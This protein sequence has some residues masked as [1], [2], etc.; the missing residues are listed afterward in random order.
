MLSDIKR[1]QLMRLVI[2]LLMVHMTYFYWSGILPHQLAFSPIF[3]ISI[4]NTFWLFHLSGL[5]S[6]LI[7]KPFFLII[8][9]LLLVAIAIALI[10]KDSQPL[11]LLLLVVYILI[12]LLQQSYSSTLTKINVIF[13]IVWLPFCFTKGMFS[14]TWKLPRYYLAYLMVS[15]GLFKIINGGLFNTDQLVNILSNQ[16]IDLQYY[17]SLNLSNTLGKF[18][19]NNSW[20]AKIGYLFMTLLELSFI[21]ILFTKRYDRIMAVVLLFFCFSIFLVMRIYILDLT[22]LVLV[23]LPLSNEID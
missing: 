4:D 2:M 6:F 23:L 17:N 18:L 1:H 12:N 10:F 16:H 14:F 11:C 19:Q 3:D 7:Q 21:S 9:E 8:I 13:P 22:Y 5:P 15:A 20:L